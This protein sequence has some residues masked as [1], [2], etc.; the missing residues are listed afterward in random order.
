MSTL[1][2]P[3]IFKLFGILCLILFLQNAVTQDS[4]YYVDEV[5]GQEV[6]KHL[7][8]WLQQKV[9]VSNPQNRLEFL[10]DWLESEPATKNR[11]LITIAEFANSLA[12]NLKDELNQAKAEFFLIKYKIEFNPDDIQLEAHLSKLE[13]A[14]Q[15]F[16]ES[17]QKE[18]EL[19]A[20]DQLLYLKYYRC[21]RNPDEVER[22]DCLQ[23]ILMEFEGILGDMAPPENDSNQDDKIIHRLADLYLTKSFVYFVLND[24]DNYKKWIKKSKQLAESVGYDRGIAHIY[25]TEALSLDT[26]D[27]HQAYQNSLA[28]YKLKED[29]FQMSKTMR[30]Y[31][32]YSM[33]QWKKAMYEPTAY[34]WLK[35]AIAQL[36]K[37]ERLEIHESC[38]LYKLLA[39]AYHYKF[40]Y[41]KSMNYDSYP[42]AFD[43]MHYYYNKTINTAVNEKDVHCLLTAITDLSGVCATDTCYQLIRLAKDKITTLFMEE[44]DL[45]KK[46]EESIKRNELQKKEESNQRIIGWIIAFFIVIGIIGI[47]ISK[48]R[49]QRKTLENT[50]NKLAALQAR[51]DVHFISNVTNNINSLIG[52][53]RNNDASNYLID[54]QRL[55]RSLL[56][57]SDVDY[58]TLKQEVNTLSSY[59]SL[60]KLRMKD[61]LEYELE[62]DEELS[63]GHLQVVSLMLQPFVEKCSSTRHTK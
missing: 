9:M 14:L 22:E 61:K 23:S 34:P 7:P 42:V 25:R 38:D 21:M 57:F 54:F 8:P 41:L 63:M 20:L 18:K 12:T 46:V 60:E 45:V 39:E 6:Y 58:I 4:V 59:L 30:E 32:H 47:F 16:R 50:K 17:R 19:A 62:I 27:V 3:K 31:G 5:E 24:L 36:K 51:M 56:Q 44:S 52:Q 49:L 53:K 33:E 26:S 48:I 55:C 29:S 37:T 13:K 35:R 15:T 43:S 2:T 11:T 40:N 10:L 1:F 28:I